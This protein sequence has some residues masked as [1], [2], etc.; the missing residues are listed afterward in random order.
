[1]SGESPYTLVDGKK[2]HLYERNAYPDHFSAIPNYKSC[3]T[4]CTGL[5][6]YNAIVEAGWN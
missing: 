2:V 6:D 3:F 4:D 5:S 1:M